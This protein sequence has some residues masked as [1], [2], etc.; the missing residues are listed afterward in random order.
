MINLIYKTYNLNKLHVK[1]WFMKNVAKGHLISKGLFLLNSSKKRTK[2][3]DLVT[4]IP[5]TNSQIW[6]WIFMNF[7]SI[8]T[9]LGR[10]LCFFLIVKNYSLKNSWLL[11][12]GTFDI[13]CRIQWAR[14]FQLLNY[15]SGFE[16][17]VLLWVQNYFGP[18]K[19]FWLSTDI[20]LVVE[21]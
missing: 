8:R 15:K 14:H 5:T 10:L 16:C 2:K 19:A 18:S 20:S 1:D 13:G 3:F 12:I 9:S 4:I 7:W 21:F 6:V 11:W 17:L